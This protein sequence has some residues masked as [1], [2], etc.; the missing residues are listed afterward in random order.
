[1]E[2]DELKSAW[3]QYDKKLTENLKLNV[4]LLKRMN[5][6]KSSRETGRLLNYEIVTTIINGLFIIWI[7]IVT[8]NHFY[9]TKFLVS[10]I[11][12]II[13]MLPYFLFSAIKSNMLLR[14]DYFNSSVLD[15]QKKMNLFN[16]KYLKFRKWEFGL[17]PLLAFAIIPITGLVVRNFDFDFLWERYC[18]GV[19]VSL[20]IGYPLAIWFYKNWYDKKIKNTQRFLKEIEKFESEG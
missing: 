4:E 5:L 16:Q 11:A 15:L 17:V 18:I 10:G 9:E 7:F 6:D 12:T 3:A 14:I 13:I 19:L 20:V 2:L 1:M 8:I